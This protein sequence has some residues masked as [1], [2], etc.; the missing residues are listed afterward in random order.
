MKFFRIYSLHIS[1]SQI[2]Q[3]I[4][5]LNDHLMRLALN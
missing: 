4:W 5:H 2:F 3:F 1:L